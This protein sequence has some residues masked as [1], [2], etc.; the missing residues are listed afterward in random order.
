M[1]VSQ[2]KQTSSSLGFFFLKVNKRKTDNIEGRRIWRVQLHG[3]L[4]SHAFEYQ[5][6]F[7]SAIQY[8]QMKQREFLKIRLRMIYHTKDECHRYRLENSFATLDIQMQLLFH[9]GFLFR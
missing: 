6:S 5:L 2:I 3:T 8:G 1:L 9:E 7:I 4:H